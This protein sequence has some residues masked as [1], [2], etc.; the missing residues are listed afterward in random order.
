MSARKS[1]DFIADVE[2]QFEWYAVNADWDIADHYL[3]AVEATCQLLAQHPLLG[4][5]AGFS[6]PRLRDWRFIVVPR[7]FQKHILFYEIAG[8][9]VR[10]RRAMHGHRDL[11]RRL[12]EPPEMN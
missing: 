12:V 7:P 9:D 4:P 6:H 10:L 3:T 5:V 1:G 8:D 2:R 11:P